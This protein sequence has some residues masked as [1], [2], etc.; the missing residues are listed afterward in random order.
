MIQCKVLVSVL[1]VSLVTGLMGCRPKPSETAQKPA[2]LK[3]VDTKNSAMNEDESCR[4]F[5]QKFYDWRISQILDLFCAHT[6]RGTS[7]TQESIDAEEA[8]C[9]TAS[10]YRNAEQ[11]KATEV[12]SPALR[13]YLEMEK[14]EQTKNA[15][16]GLDFDPYLNSQ[17]P[18][19]KYVV[20]HVQ[21]QGNRCDAVVHGSDQ[22]ARREEVMPELS[23]QNGQ[24]MIENF[25]YKYDLND[26]KGMRDNDLI[27]MIKDYLKK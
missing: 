5:V 7:A 11:L 16:A 8:E 4:A 24:W 15:D 20:D 3:T 23:R 17:D 14:R 1:I 25:H 26:G 22:G 21:V 13:H 18:S 2:A 6:L 19:P 10:A 27:Q 9:R 12:L